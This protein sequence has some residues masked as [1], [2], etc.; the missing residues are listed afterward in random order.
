M[1]VPQPKTP[2]QHKDAANDAG[3]KTTEVNFLACRTDNGPQNQSM[4]WNQLAAMLLSPCHHGSLPLTEYLA[5][6]ADTKKA[7]KDHMGWMPVSLKNQAAGRNA[8]NIKAV[9]Y[10]VLDCDGGITFDHTQ[11]L[12]AGFEA[13]MHT[14]YSHTPDQ[15]KFRVV[16]PLSAPIPSNKLR[17]M[18]QQMDALLGGHLDKACME[19]ARFFYLPACPPDAKHLFRSKRLHGEYVDR[20]L[21]TTS[22]ASIPSAPAAAAATSGAATSALALVAPTLGV[23]SRNTRLASLVGKTIALGKDLDYVLQL[24]LLMN[25]KE[26]S[27]LPE[28]EVEATVKSIF[29]TAERKAHISETEIS[30]IVE[31]M[32]RKYAFLT[33]PSVIISI[34]DKKRQSKEMM[35]DRYANAMAVVGDGLKTKKVSHFQIWSESHDRREHIDLTFRPGQPE[36]VDNQVNLWTGWGAEPHAGDIQPWIDMLDYMFGA[37][38][39]E[40]NWMEQWLA[41]PLQHPGTKLT[42]AVVLWSSRQGVGKSLLGETVSALYGAHG[43]TITATELHDK[44]NNWS[45]DALFVLGEENS[46]ADRRAD[47]NRLKHLITGDTM[48]VERKYFDRTERPNMLN[49]MFTSNH[50]NAFYL[51]GHDRRFFV[52]SIDAQPRDPAF[53]ETYAQWK[54]S[55]AGQSALMDHLLNLDLSGFDPYGHAPQTK[56]KVEMIDQSK[57]ALERWVADLVTDEFIDSQLGGEIVSLKD[58]LARFH[59]HEGYGKSNETALSVALRRLVPYES[60]RISIDGDR[61]NFITIRN[62]DS[63]SQ[64]DNKAWADEYRVVKRHAITSGMLR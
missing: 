48:F 18:C 57:T 15:H 44:F 16:L 37:G 10:V 2:T 27:P 60:R 3:T 13:V 29:K 61:T 4:T 58:L 51:E 25:K 19:P 12:L 59:R 26:P 36:I 35:R 32:N 1:A 43:K 54:D 6:D 17:S 64:K 62:V 33:K 56:A 28:K 49:F 47:S 52:W 46:S 39:S 20:K 38:T 40:R 41:Y 53:Y 63:W 30:K 9:H 22:L 24:A 5:A 7:E 11:D 42:S 21:A 55:R 50:P 45:E 34:Q 31:Q 23:G 8:D 14:S